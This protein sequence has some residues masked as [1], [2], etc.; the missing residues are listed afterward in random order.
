M[1]EKNTQLQQVLYDKHFPTMNL[2]HS[3]KQNFKNIIDLS[4][5]TTKKSITPF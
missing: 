5:F 3:A 2:F 1:M 4:L